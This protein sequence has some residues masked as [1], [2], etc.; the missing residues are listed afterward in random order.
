MPTM[1]TFSFVRVTVFQ[2][3][4]LLLLVTGTFLAWG[5]VVAWSAGLGGLV[6]LIPGTW[7]AYLVFRHTGARSME[8]MVRST[9]MGELVKLLMMGAGF[10]LVFALVEPVSARAVFGGFVLI[11]L[12]GMLGI[13]WQANKAMHVG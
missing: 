5:K 11:H 9:Y 1:I 10:G 6:S 13:A 2:S 8:R 3:V 12:A 4:V 7:F